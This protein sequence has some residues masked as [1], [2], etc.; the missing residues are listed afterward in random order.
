VTGGGVVLLPVVGMGEVSEGD[1]L[2]SLLISA[3]GED[4]PLRDGDVVVVTSKVVSKTE[5][6]V[7][8]GDRAGVVAADTDRVVATRGG[9]RIVRTHHGLVLAA[10]GVDASNVVVGSVLS[11]P[12]DPDASAVRLRE[13][14]LERA[15]A[16]V[17]VVVSDTAGR[18]WRTGQT[19]IAIGAAGLDVLDDH[20]GRTDPYGNPL[21][22]TAPAVADELAAAADLV[23]GKL[24]RRPAA[25][26]RGLA[27]LVL[28]AGEHGPGARALVRPEADDMF[29]LGARDAIQAAVDAD[30]AGWRG[31]GAPAPVDDVLARL[32]ALAGAPAE[33]VDGGVRVPLPSATA[34]DADP[35]AVGR[36]E[37]RLAVAAY[38][39]GWSVRTVAPAFVDFAPSAALAAADG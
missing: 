14:L 29:G 22:V 4:A 8:Y 1:D 25:V 12:V 2:A 6:R 26:V 15:D 37:A 17:A 30:P 18:A 39:L 23:K 3:L 11:L 5:G 28:P 10:A 35:R 16:N 33:A 7:R 34:P 27:R 20:T 38:G 19:D 24:A 32:G 21:A 9:T 36:L 31:V 13:A